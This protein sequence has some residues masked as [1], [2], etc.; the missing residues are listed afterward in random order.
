MLIRDA[1]VEGRRVD[2]RIGERVEQIG[3]LVAGPAEEVLDAAGGALLP[4]LHD[5][6]IH[7]LSLAASLDSVHLGELATAA[8]RHDGWIRVIGWDGKMTLDRARLDELRGDVPVRVQHRSG[9]LWVFNTAALRALDLDVKGDGRVYRHDGLLRERMPARTP[10]LDRVG[11]LLAR[12]GITGATDATVSNGAAEAELLA[13]LPQRLVV[14]SVT[15][16]APCKV[17]LHE[18]ELPSLSDL[19][20]SVAAARRAGR[21]VAVHAVTRAELALALAVLES[22]DRVEHAG[23][24]PPEMAAMLAARDVT[25]VTQPHFPVE[26]AEQYASE[27]DPGDRPWLYPC[28]L[29]VEKGVPL[30]AGTDAPFGDPDPWKAIAAAIDRGLSPSRALDLFLTPPEAPGGIP[31]RVAENMPADL[32]LLDT[33]LAGALAA[34]SSSLVRATWVGGSR[35]ET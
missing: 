14:M 34:P 33:G 28:T 1:E 8:P 25:V 12:F 23:V 35:L 17:V 13:G 6:H 9:Q 19:E 7:V 15:D 18:P 30:G 10:D 3:S 29:F 11:R 24:C 27:V 21:P 26:R 2:V 20:D 4:G 32:C 31:R 5:H 16:G 22:G